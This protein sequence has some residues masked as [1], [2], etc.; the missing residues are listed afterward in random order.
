MDGGDDRMIDRDQGH[1]EWNVATSMQREHD[2]CPYTA[3]IATDDWLCAKCGQ[4]GPTDDL[5]DVG[6]V[7][8]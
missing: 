1:A 6:G 5:T 2:G 8:R 3:V 7:I 4:G